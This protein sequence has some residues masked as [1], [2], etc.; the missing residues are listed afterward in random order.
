M[1]I[2][3]SLPWRTRVVGESPRAAPVSAANSHIL[4]RDH[5]ILGLSSNARPQVARSIQAIKR[6]S[7]IWCSSRNAPGRRERRAHVGADDRD[8]FSMSSRS[9]PAYVMAAGGTAA[10]RALQN[11]MAA[12]RE[13]TC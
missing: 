10:E 9:T 3:S 12:N 6:P 5:G 2:P 1:L 4:R 13:I 11:A 7:V 8:C